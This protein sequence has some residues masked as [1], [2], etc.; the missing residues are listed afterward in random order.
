[1]VVFDTET[2]V[3]NLHLPS[4]LITLEKA[5]GKVIELTDCFRG[6]IGQASALFGGGGF[7]GNIQDMLVG[8]LEE[9]RPVINKVN[10]A[11][12][13]LCLTTFICVRIAKL[14]SIY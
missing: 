3:H 12:H 9:T 10:D 4:F 1:M 14:L 6:L 13:D 2:T 8:L 11:F 7:P 5:L